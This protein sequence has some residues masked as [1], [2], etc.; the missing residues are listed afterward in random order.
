MPSSDPTLRLYALVR[1][2]LG[3]DAGKIASQS[4]H[5][6]LGA[7]INP[8]NDPAILAEYHSEYPQSPG[9]K[10]CLACKNLPQLLR[11]E[12][13]AKEAGIATFKVVDSGCQNFF[14]GHPVVTALGIGPATKEQIEHITKRFQLLK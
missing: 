12:A 1:T 7:Y 10:V 2:D 8:A 14:N 9:T 11:A 6:Y 3:M 13:E 5:A 4:G